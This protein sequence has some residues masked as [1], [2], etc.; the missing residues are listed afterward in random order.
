MKRTT[1]R[2][3]SMISAALTLI[4]IIASFA[5]VAF[6]KVIVEDPAFR[7]EIEADF[8]SDPAL[9]VEDVDMFFE[10]IGMIE[11]FGWFFTILLV[12]SLIANVVGIISIWNNKNPKLAGAMFILAGLFAYVISPTSILLYI[13]GIMCFVRKAPLTDDTSFVQ[14]QYDDTLRPL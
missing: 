14:N 8:L 2:V 5:I 12:V 4:G 3:L 9:G 13:A 1:E 7:S 11:G 10:L 6:M